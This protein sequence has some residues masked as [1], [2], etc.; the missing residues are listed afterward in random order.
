MSSC[1]QGSK[2][3]FREIPEAGGECEDKHWAF[4]QLK[5][6]LLI[7][8]GK[9]SATVESWGLSG[10]VTDVTRSLVL[11][12]LYPLIVLVGFMIS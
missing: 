11:V 8:T 1:S 5:L 4:I 10:H 3:A 6:K 9:L 12:L 7:Q 2:G